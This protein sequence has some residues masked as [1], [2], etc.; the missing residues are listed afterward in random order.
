MLILTFMEKYGSCIITCVLCFAN[1][2]ITILE[3]LL[4][5]SSRG[6]PTFLKRCYWLVRQE[7]NTHVTMKDLISA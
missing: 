7:Y 5:C 2:P 1:Q 4:N 6:W 3:L